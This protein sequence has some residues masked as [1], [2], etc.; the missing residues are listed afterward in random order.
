MPRPSAVRPSASDSPGRA[1]SPH[2]TVPGR[3]VPDLPGASITAP[4]Q[5]PGRNRSGQR[6]LWPAGCA[7]NRSDDLAASNQYLLPGGPR[8]RVAAWPG[9]R[10]G[11]DHVRRDGAPA[12]QAAAGRPPGSPQPALPARRS[13][14]GWCHHPESAGN[15]RWPGNEPAPRARGRIAGSAV[16]ALDG[17][18]GACV[19][20][21]DSKGLNE[22]EG[23]AI[24]LAEERS[25]LSAS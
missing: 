19:D 24:E 25:R 8:C 10:P 3:A 4:R 9:R 15:R 21:V 1:R 22:H 11:R 18:S 14:A 17:I 5:T 20:W 2:R 23:M 16:A 13:R 12:C 7:I 6:P